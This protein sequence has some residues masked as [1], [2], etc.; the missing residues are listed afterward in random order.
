MAQLT[1][2]PLAGFSYFTG[3][4]WIPDPFFR[5]SVK[6]I[7]RAKHGS[8]TGTYDAEASCV[9]LFARECWLNHNDLVGTLHPSQVRGLVAP[10]TAKCLC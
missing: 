9:P 1:N 8:D 5:I 10:N 6:N 7:H 2:R 3:D 4:S